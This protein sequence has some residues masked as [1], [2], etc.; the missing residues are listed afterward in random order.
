MWSP[1]AKQAS[2][3]AIEA[4]AIFLFGAEAPFMYVSTAT[5]SIA[6]AAPNCAIVA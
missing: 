5:R 4:G 6:H 1:S 3:Y 2:N